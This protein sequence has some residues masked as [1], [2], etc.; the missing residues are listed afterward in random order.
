MV[1]RDAVQTARAASASCSSE[2][3]KASCRASVTLGREGATQRRD[4]AGPRGRRA[5]R[6]R[7]HLPAQGR[8]RQGRGRARALRSTPCSNASFAS[9]SSTASASCWS[10][11]RW[12]ASA[13][14]RSPRL[15]IDAVPDITNN[16]VQI[17]TLAPSLSPVEVEK[18]VTFPIETALAGIPG[19]EYTRSLSRNG[20]SQVTAVFDDDV[21]IYFA[22]QQVGE[23][24]GEARESLPP[25]AE[26]RDGRR[27]RPASAR[28][29]CG[30]SSTSTRAAR[31][32]RAPTASRA[33]SPTASYL[34]PEGERLRDRRRA[35]RLPA[36]GAGL[37]HP[38]A[39][40]GRAGRRRRR[41]DRRLREAVPRPA[42]PAE[43]RRL[44]PDASATCI[45][46]L[47][48][49][50]VS[51]GAGYVEHN[52][53]GVRRAR[54]GPHRDARA[55]RARSS[56]ASAAGVPIRV[57]DVAERRGRPRAAHG[58]RQRERRGG[59]RRH[60][61]DADRREQPHGRRGGRRAG[62]RE[63]NADAA[64]R[65]S[66]PRRCSNRTELVDATIAH[67][68]EEPRRGRDPRDRRALPAARQLP[69]RADHR[70]RDPALD[71][72]DRD[73]HGADAASAA[74]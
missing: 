22:R 16:Q 65:T 66:A 1:P 12:P 23:R 26:P 74:T 53:R 36:H 21:D 3:A 57:R 29:T 33:G 49:N 54:G 31:A 38:P 37:D 51:T 73:R 39:A 32:R 4:R 18:Q 72:A 30:P 20:F 25:G 68:R 71:A 14:G 60:G 67:R 11:S 47:E 42:R 59:R 24:L 6:R 58:Q 45:E 46:A 10:C 5:R 28:S 8:A 62:W 19:L 41:R 64:A 9:R 50:N 52:G 7:Q 69:R 35:R 34:T 15:P 17:N 13:R 56:S 44:R 2:T 61:A 70:A 27:S 55:D 63:V 40:Q 43:A 48:R